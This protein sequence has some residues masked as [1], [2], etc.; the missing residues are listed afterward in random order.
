M[1][2]LVIFIFYLSSGEV[3]NAAMLQSIT[4]ATSNSAPVSICHR[5]DSIYFYIQRPIAEQVRGQLVKRTARVLSRSQKCNAASFTGRSIFK[6][7]R[8]VG[9][10]GDVVIVFT[11]AELCAGKPL[12]RVNP[13][14]R[15]LI[16]FNCTGIHLTI[17][18]T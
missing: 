5:V 10:V 16:H 8:R 7:F 2:F 17:D 4:S 18:L 14:Q 6:L 12:E 9:D 1:R 11:L 13:M 3:A 15:S